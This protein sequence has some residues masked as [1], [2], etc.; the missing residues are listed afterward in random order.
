MKA[1]RRKETHGYNLGVT[2]ERSKAQDDRRNSGVGITE[3]MFL[4]VLCHD[5]PCDCG[6][7]G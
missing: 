2:L 6:P 5:Q 3:V 7:F 4:C 1:K